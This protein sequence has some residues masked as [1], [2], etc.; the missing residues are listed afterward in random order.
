MLSDQDLVKQILE[1]DAHAFEILFERY[2]EMIERHLARLVRDNAV[3]QDLAQEAFL[4]VW[5]RAEQ[6]NESGPFKAW[7]YRIATNL[8]LNHLRSVR[9]RRE[10]PL[11]APNEQTEDEGESL[12]PAW[13]LDAATLG[14]DASLELA[15]EREQFRRLVES[16]P[17]E[18]RQVYRL[19]H[20]MEMSLR[21]AADELGIPEGT[22]KSRLHYAKKQLARA[23][24]ELDTD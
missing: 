4:R 6:W 10:Q 12:A 18:K 8:A 21:D 7:L 20:Q 14:P 23:W 16:L 22:A 2:G 15:E 24:Q 17:E 5:T 19:V 11:D 1:R 13:M 9:R 3:A